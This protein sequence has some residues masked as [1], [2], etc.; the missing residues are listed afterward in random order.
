LN[1]NTITLLSQPLASCPLKLPPPPL[2]QPPLLLFATMPLPPHLED[3]LSLFDVLSGFQ[4]DAEFAPNFD[5]I[6]TDF[7]A[8]F[9]FEDAFDFDS[10]DSGAFEYDNLSCKFSV[11]SVWRQRQRNRRKRQKNCV[12]CKENVKKSC[13]YQYFT[14]PELTR[15]ITHNLSSS[16]CFG[17]F[18][19]WFCMFLRKVE[20]LTT[21]LINHEYITWPRSHHLCK[22][23]WEHLELLV[24]SALYL[25]ATGATFCCCKPLCGICTLEIRKFFYIFIRALVNMK[26]EYRLVWAK[27]VTLAAICLDIFSASFGIRINLCIN[28]SCSSSYV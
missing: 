24:M 3:P 27:K 17:E 22:V 2:P 16:N 26:D 8:D 23:F 11:K 14:R 28:V 4:E 7:G 9:T 15:E 1:P 21:I 10:I 12:F 6:G 20:E 5:F 19:Q 13:W 25:L 18:C